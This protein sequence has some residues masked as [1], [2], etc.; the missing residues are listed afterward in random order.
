LFQPVFKGK[1]RAVGGADNQISNAQPVVVATQFT[2][3]ESATS[4]QAPPNSFGPD[5]AGNSDQTLK[6]DLER[7]LKVIPSLPLEDLF[8]LFTFLFQILV[9][10]DLWTFIKANSITLPVPTKPRTKPGKNLPIPTQGS[11]CSFSKDLISAILQDSKAFTEPVVAS[12]RNLVHE[13]CSFSLQVP[14]LVAYDN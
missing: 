1:A 12:I 11:Q 13:V 4:A 9:K 6:A 3:N 10:D 14:K 5:N 8:K 2:A 7:S